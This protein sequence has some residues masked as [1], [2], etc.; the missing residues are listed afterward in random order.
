MTL[1]EWNEKF[2]VSVARMD[3][4]HKHFLKLLNKLNEAIL[5][6]GDRELVGSA[7]NSLHVYALVHFRDEEAILAGCGYPGLG[8]QRREHLFFVRQIQEM[9]ASHQGGSPVQLSSIVC[10]LR[11]WFIHHITEEDKRY[12]RCVNGNRTDA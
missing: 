12:E 7:I 10:F 2:S 11:D 9:E 3:E 6:E 8:Q 1:F 4:Q 5:R